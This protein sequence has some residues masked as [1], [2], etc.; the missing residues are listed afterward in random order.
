[1]VL[2]R[3]TPNDVGPPVVLPLDELPEE[4]VDDD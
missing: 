4:P 1:V 3:T 2:V